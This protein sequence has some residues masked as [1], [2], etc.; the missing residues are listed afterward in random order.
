MSCLLNDA[1]R[2]AVNEMCPLVR[3]PVGE[4][5]GDVREE[6]MSIVREKS[7]QRVGRGNGG[8]EVI[9]VRKVTVSIRLERDRNS[10]WD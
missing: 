7:R 2:I 9:V 4:R 5:R 3:Y 10:S 1:E 8:L 6:E